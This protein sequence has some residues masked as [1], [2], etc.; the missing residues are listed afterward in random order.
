MGFVHLKSCA[1]INIGLSVTQR[2]NDGYHNIETLFQEIDLCDEIIFSRS[3]NS[4]TIK[5]DNPELPLDSS[6][7][8]YHA[9]EL[10]KS[11]ASASGGLNIDIK[12]RIPMG[13]GL[14]GG[15]SNAAATLVA[16]NILWNN[17]L[18]SKHL[19]SLAQKI[20]SDVP[21]FITGGTAIGRGRG[22]ELSFLKI[23]DDWFAVLVCPG[24]NISTKW[25]YGELKIALTNEKKITNFNA[26]FTDWLIDRFQSELYND[27]EVPVFKL[28]PELQ[29]IKDQLYKKGA[30]YAS[31]SGSGSTIYGL[32]KSSKVG[33][34]VQKF[35]SNKYVSFFCSPMTI[36]QA[37]GGIIR[38]R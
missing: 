28:Y 35:F 38:N 12:K 22:E 19:L 14:G 13:G 1:K 26:L 8:M 4:T 5:S 34:R 36:R 16:A 17:P 29:H 6:N 31:M 18:S 32:F 24:I 20:G 10:F 3:D 30:F 33:L 2:R 9:F 21:F 37:P 11:N 23:P 7:L 15:S 25:A 27:F